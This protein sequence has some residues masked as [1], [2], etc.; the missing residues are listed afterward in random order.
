MHAT[1]VTLALGLVAC[2]IAPTQVVSAPVAAAD[3][4][5][6]AVAIPEASPASEASLAKRHANIR[7]TW[8]RPNDDNYESACGHPIHNS[9]MICAISIKT[10][11]MDMCGKK[12]NVHN[13]GKSVQVTLWDSCA[14]CPDNGLDLSL[15]AFKEIGDLD[16]GVLSVDWEWA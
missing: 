7:T 10:F 16:T 15:A 11:N 12:I 4:A 1:T 2:L 8:Y 9:D 6:V 5:A 3:A 14:A 13:E